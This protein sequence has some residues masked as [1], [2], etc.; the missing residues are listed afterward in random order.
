MRTTAI[1]APGTAQM[2]ESLATSTSSTLLFQRHPVGTFQPRLSKTEIMKIFKTP[3]TDFPICLWAAT[4][5]CPVLSG[6]ETETTRSENCH[7]SSAGTKSRS[8]PDLS[9]H[10]P[11]YLRSPLKTPGARVSQNS[12]S[13]LELLCDPSSLGEPQIFVSFPAFRK[14][15]SPMPSLTFRET[16]TPLLAMSS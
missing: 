11:G 5:C 14:S 16:Q 15:K 9:G 10:S 1:L 12:L 4:C 6:K 7:G 2:W 13:N 3:C 8:K